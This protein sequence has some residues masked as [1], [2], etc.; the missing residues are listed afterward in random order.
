MK[1][2]I[3]AIDYNPSSQKVAETGYALAKKMNAEVVIVHVISDAAYYAMPYA[4]IMGYEGFIASNTAMLAE[5]LKTEAGN[6][7][8]ATAKH[9]GDETIQTV[10]LEGSVADT[11]LSFAE[12]KEADLLVMG[13]HSHSGLYKL[14][15]GDVAAK[16]LQHA[17]IPMLIIP[18]KEIKKDEN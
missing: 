1:K 10:I 8:K 6:Y 5:D 17:T 9:L 18:N 16:V 14:L 12:K 13:S 2:I 7:L 11:I 4:P 3:I 15:I